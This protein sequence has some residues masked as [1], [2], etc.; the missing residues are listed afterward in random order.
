MPCHLNIPFHFTPIL[1]IH[2]LN[3]LSNNKPSMKFCIV[4]LEN[5][6]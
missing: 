2:M 1:S 3:I 4:F 5:V 6:S